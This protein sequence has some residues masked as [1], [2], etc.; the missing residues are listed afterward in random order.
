MFAFGKCYGKE[1]MSK[2]DFLL[3]SKIVKWLSPH[4]GP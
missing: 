3:S 1:H 4:G 2:M